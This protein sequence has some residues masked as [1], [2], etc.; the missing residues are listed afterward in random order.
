MHD[1]KASTLSK[2]EVGQ[3]I[4]VTPLADARGFVP[5]T[6]TEQTGQVRGFAR[7]KD[8][9]AEPKRVTDR[10]FTP[11]QWTGKV[12]TLTLDDGT[13]TEPRYG[14]A[15]VYVFDVP[16]WLPPTDE[17]K[18]NRTV[19]PE[20]DLDLKSGTRRVIV[21]PDGTMHVK[22]WTGGTVVERTPKGRLVRID[23]D[24]EL[25]LVH[26]FPEDEQLDEQLAGEPGE[27]AHD[28]KCGQCKGFGVVRK[29]GSQAGKSYRTLNGATA[30]TTNG[31]STQCPV[32]KGTGLTARAA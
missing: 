20:M 15:H 30:A 13:K 27:H 26:D 23:A 17:P 11:D 18:P 31:N 6:T 1:A 4:L 25:T 9:T 12:W 7:P 24:G 29:R 19:T 5:G 14:T 21:D 2:I 3:L 22:D 28:D 8:K 10:T 32:C 16:A